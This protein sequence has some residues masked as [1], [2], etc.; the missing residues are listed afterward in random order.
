[1]KVVIPSGDTSDYQPED[2]SPGMTETS[3]VGGVRLIQEDSQRMPLTFD[4]L[5][6]LASVAR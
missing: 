4:S 1:L 2:F 5:L 3:F 6:A